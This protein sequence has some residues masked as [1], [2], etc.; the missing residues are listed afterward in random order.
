MTCACNTTGTWPLFTSGSQ[1]ML[2]PCVGEHEKDLK[3]GDLTGLYIGM[4]VYGM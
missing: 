1:K 3:C 4:H 2:G